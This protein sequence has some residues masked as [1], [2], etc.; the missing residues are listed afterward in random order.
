MIGYY[1]GEPNVDSE[2][3]ENWKWMGIEEIKR[4]VQL[5]PGIYT[6]WFKIIF[7]EFY[8]FLEEHKI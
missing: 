3:V 5:N 4:D 2:E 8:H 7:E 1:D 6:V